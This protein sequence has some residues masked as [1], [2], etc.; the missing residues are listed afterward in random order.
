MQKFGEKSIFDKWLQMLQG[1]NQIQ[2]VWDRFEKGKDET[3]PLNQNYARTFPQMKF[4]IKSQLL[5]MSKIQ[6]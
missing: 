3:G 4:K 1:K 5:K 6:L 2:E